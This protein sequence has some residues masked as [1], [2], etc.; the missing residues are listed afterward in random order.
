M[1]SPKIIGIFIWL[2]PFLMAS[3]LQISGNLNELEKSLVSL[4]YKYANPDLKM[5]DQIIIIS[6]DNDSLTKFAQHPDFGRW[7][8]ERKVYLPVLRFIAQQK[9]KIILFD[10][11]F[12]EPSSDDSALVKFNGEFA[13]VSH[14]L[15][16]QGMKESLTEIKIVPDNIKKKAIGKVENEDCAIEFQEMI[17]PA[18]KIGET[19]PLFHALGESEFGSRLNTEDLLLYK[20]KNW[21][22]PSLPIVALNSVIPIQSIKFN[23]KSFTIIT[24]KKIV[25]LPLSNCYYN[26]H[27]YPKNKLT[28]NDN[29][30]PFYK[31]KNL[32]FKNDT[33]DNKMKQINFQDKI[34]LIGVTATSIFDEKI[35]PY[36]NLPSVFLNA[37]AISNLL[38]K[39][40]LN[41]VPD[42]INLY[43]EFILSI[44]GIFLMFFSKGVI[45]RSL[46]P[47]IILILYVLAC[48]ILFYFSISLNIAMFLV[49]YCISFIVS[50]AY[51]SFHEGR[52]NMRLL[53]DTIIL[54]QKLLTFNESLEEK[55]KERTYKL[56]QKTIELGIEK[57]KSEEIFNKLKERNEIIENDLD[58]ARKIHKNLLPQTIPI[59]EQFSFHDYYEP[60]DKVGGDLYG[61][62]PFS[63]GDIGVFILDVTGHGISA[64][65]VASMFKY[66]LEITVSKFSSPSE[67]LFQL[68]DIL[69]NT[70]Q[71]YFLTIFYMILKKNGEVLCS[72]G[73][74]TYPI[75][76]KKKTNELIELTYKGRLLGALPGGSWNDNKFFMEVGDRLYL[77]TDGITEACKNGTNENKELMFGEKMLMDVIADNHNLHPDEIIK[78]IISSVKEF[79]D[80]QDIEDDITLLI[81]EKKG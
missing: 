47:F 9:P 55:V 11:L 39:H 66:Q 42:E 5:S 29:I 4:R 41:R 61:F 72:N 78:K 46:L 13:N 68:N 38:Q 81:I 32:Y 73:G 71:N 49:S 75:L 77:Y 36:G 8:W 22:Y 16:F 59:N 43:V 60:M 62:I 2:L 69:Y 45:N 25:T 20:H 17:P 80:S 31:F 23:H 52:E 40:F 21:Y 12:T 10:I 35:T 44:L 19:S 56:E 67:A 76:Y 51:I 24:N 34:V 6:I 30:V 14:T 18:N 74:H 26:Y 37:N 70:V 28:E 3:I 79:T 48:G 27:Y 33:Q 50:F 57:E 64:A 65:F 63:S 58:K 53:D 54:N 15:F 1:T 7:P